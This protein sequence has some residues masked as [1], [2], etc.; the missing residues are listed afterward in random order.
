MIAF[1]LTA[2]KIVG[3]DIF[4]AAVLLA[5][6]GVG[7]LVAGSVDLHATAWL[8]IGSIPGV[9]LGGRFTVRLPDRTLR[10]A[11]AATLFLAGVKLV[12]P[13]DGDAI[14]IGGAVVALVAV[15][16]GWCA[17]SRASPRSAAARHERPAA[18]SSA[19]ASP[20]RR[21]GSRSACASTDELVGLPELGRFEDHAGYDGVILGLPGSD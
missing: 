3:T 7:H 6:A 10:F 16:V 14:V 4:H 15:V 1:P 13:P 11:L 8:L 19:C 12:D 17:G 9:L 5:V 20:G 2:A 21:S 18:R